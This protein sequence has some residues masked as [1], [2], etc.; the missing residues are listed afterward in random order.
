MPSSR[1]LGVAAALGMAAAA[2]AHA[3]PAGEISVTICGGGEASIPLPMKPDH[4]A[5]DPANVA[6][7]ATAPCGLDRKGRRPPGNGSG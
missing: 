7:H 2:P 3:A 5:P 4:D 6:C 1:I